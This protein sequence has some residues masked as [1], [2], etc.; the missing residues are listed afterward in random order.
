VFDVNDNTFNFNMAEISLTKESKDG[1]GFGL[2]LNYGQDA[3]LINFLD[4][5]EAPDS[6]EVQQAYVSD[7]AFGGAL[8]LKLGRV[9]T[10]AGAEVIEGPANYNISRSFLFGWAIPFTHTGLRANVGT[11][12]KNV[13]LILGLNNGWDFVN[14]TNKGKTLELQVGLAPVEM[15][16]L[17]VNGYYG[18]E[19]TTGVDSDNRGLI[20]L[21]ATIKPAGGMTFAVNYDRGSQMAAGG[22]GTGSALWQGYALYANLPVGDKHAVTLRGEVFDD[23]DGF[24]TGTA[25]TLRELTLTF[26]CKM[27]ENLEWRAEVRHDESNQDLF[28]DDEGTAKDTQNTI[29]VAAYYSF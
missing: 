8:G 12:V 2:V 28:L 13:S 19:N 27:K 17:V 5:T 29:G 23:Q 9:A 11:G 16:S 15:L 18:P 25:Q 10:L 7:S 4:P 26:A 20:D 6:F 3:Q 14:D 21:V 22:P 24:R 1:I